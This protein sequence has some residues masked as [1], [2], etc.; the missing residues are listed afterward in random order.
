M[1]PLVEQLAGHPHYCVLDGY[2][3]YNHFP[4]DLDEQENA[5]LT[6]TFGVFAYYCMP[7]GSCT[8]P[9]VESLAKDYKLS[10]CGRQPFVTFSF[11]VV[12]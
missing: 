3:S 10:P 4:L 2:S 6:I 12:I 7:F 8:A 5:T 9:V 11:F 1:D